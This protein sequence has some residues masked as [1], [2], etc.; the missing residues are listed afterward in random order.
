MNVLR[1]DRD[2]TRRCKRCDKLFK[3]S[4]KYAKICSE[5][6]KENNGKYMLAITGEDRNTVKVE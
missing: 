3:T 6:R 2:Y 1:I 4:C 5:C